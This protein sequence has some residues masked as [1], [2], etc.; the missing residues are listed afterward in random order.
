MYCTVELDWSQG[1]IAVEAFVSR[2]QNPRVSLMNV[3]GF[4]VPWPTTLAVRV[5]ADRHCTCGFP[6][7]EPALKKIMFLGGVTPLCLP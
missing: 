4:K 7:Q 6:L 3:R 5:V 2:P 1:V